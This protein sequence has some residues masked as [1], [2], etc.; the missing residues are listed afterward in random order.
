MQTL[1]GRGL[2][3]KRYELSVKRPLSVAF[4]VEGD[5]GKSERLEDFD[6]AARHLGCERAWQLF[7]RDLDADQLLVVTDPDL[8]ET[9]LVQRLFTLFHDGEAL[10]RDLDAVSDPGC[11]PD[12]PRSKAR[13]SR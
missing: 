11:W 6:E 10:R 7:G 3:F 1:R 9:K 2:P 12:R 8:A 13:R 4:E 5:E